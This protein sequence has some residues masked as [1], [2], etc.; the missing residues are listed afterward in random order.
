VLRLNIDQPATTDEEFKSRAL[1]NTR[2][3]TEYHDQLA[4]KAKTTE[5]KGDTSGK[6]SEGS[7]T[8]RRDRPLIEINPSQ[9]KSSGGQTKNDLW[10]TNW[11]EE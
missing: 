2:L 4:L 11:W 3:E 6:R 10:E 5:D 9:S 8:A 1:G 7:G